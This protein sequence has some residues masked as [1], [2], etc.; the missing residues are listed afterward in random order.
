MDRSPEGA[1]VARDA[2]AVNPGRGRIVIN[3]SPG[4]S[5]RLAPDPLQRG[6]T[7]AFRYGA[8]VVAAIILGATAVW[9]FGAPGPNVEV[10]SV[11]IVVVA[12]GLAGVT[13]WARRSANVTARRDAATLILVGGA[14]LL[15]SH[16]FNL[17]EQ[18]YAISRRNEN[19]QL[20][21]LF[22]LVV[23]VAVGLSIFVARR[24]RDLQREIA[25]RSAVEE[26]LR[27]QTVVFDTIGDAVLISD[28]R[29][30]VLDANSAATTVFGY[31]RD[32][33]LG[34]TPAFWHHPDHGDV[35]R[36][37]ITASLAAKGSWA[38]DYRI[39]RRDGATRTVEARLRAI[40]GTNGQA[41]YVIGVVR[42]ISDQRLIETQLLQSQKLEAIG[43]LAA[44]IAH[45]INTPMQYVG[46]NVRF[47]G[48][49][50]RSMA[51]VLHPAQLI[52][53][54]VRESGGQT[55]LIADFDQVTERVELSSLDAELRQASDDAQEGCDRISEIVQALKGFA[56]PG[57]GHKDLADIN[58]CVRNTITVC[59]SEWKY[60]AILTTELD[61]ELPPVTCLPADIQQVVLNL[62]V[63]AAQ[64]I[65][66]SHA[67]SRT[68]GSIVVTTRRD[69]NWVEILVAD[70]GPG[71]PKAIQGR[72]FDPFFT[73]KPTGKGTG[74]G[75]SISHATIVQKHQGTLTFQSVEG[76]G[77]TFLIR[78]PLVLDAAMNAVTDVAMASAT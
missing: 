78:L 6:S 73:T 75:L 2:T 21:E 50:V 68:L 56:H 5:A 58:T 31:T 52:V 35:L 9:A 33:L 54:A 20:D 34:K 48:E 60:V 23:I 22:S 70:D 1:L 10:V 61:P 27:R 38:G 19:Y 74:Q 45:E 3:T 53:N 26:V 64:A 36:A 49:G 14:V 37:D 47:L 65:G 66:E 57:S 63:N 41:A 24:S 4:N 13:L 51:R 69:H 42:D 8:V 11:G 7:F 16:R 17:F 32:E 67:P 25:A 55:S 59:R 18:I 12:V 62:I 77:T 46:D 44:G 29:G 39:L 76:Q 30:R 28:P 15:A 40:V 43:S 71:I 72:V